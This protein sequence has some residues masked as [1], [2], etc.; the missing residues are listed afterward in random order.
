MQRVSK[1]HDDKEQRYL[2]QQ[3]LIDAEI[4]MQKNKEHLSRRY[5]YV[6]LRPIAVIDY[7]EN[8]TASIYSVHTDHL[9]TP[10]QVS[11][12]KQ[13]IVWQGDYDAFG[14][15]TVKALP[16][17]LSQDIQAKQQGLSFSLFNKAYAADNAKSGPFEFNLRFA[18][19]Y[20]DSESGYYYNWHRYYNPKTGRYLTSDPI[21]LNGGLNTY[22][23]ANQNPVSAVD[24]WGL[25]AYDPA[26]QKFY[27]EAGDKLSNISKEFGIS[28]NQL[29]RLNLQF[30]I[31]NDITR[32]KKNAFLDL[33]GTPMQLKM[34]ISMQEL[35]S[36]TY[37]YTMS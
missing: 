11:N 37:L 8:N 24:P 34:V 2:W 7:D 3:G 25:L 14:N 9:G 12:A 22:G 35:I 10:Q 13:Q 29:A 36:V 20:E 30:Y 28:L 27:V 17:G 15:V 33:R 6:G 31:S 23:Y 21:R 4:D 16:H 1:R 32:L 26:T 5:I 18:G 19:Q